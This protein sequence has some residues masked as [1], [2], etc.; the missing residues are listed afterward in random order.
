MEW[1]EAG[2]SKVK[3]SAAAATN[4]MIKKNTSDAFP[5]ELA[6]ESKDERVGQVQACASA[7][8]EEKR[9]QH[10]KLKQSRSWFQNIRAAVLS[11]KPDGAWNDGTTEEGE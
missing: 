10:S 11:W 9:G 2:A 7:E 6:E 5:K 8:E 3:P 1:N 4:S